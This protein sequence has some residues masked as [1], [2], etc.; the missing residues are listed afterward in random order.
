[1]TS[2]MDIKATKKLLKKQIEKL[3]EYH[4]WKYI[5]WKPNKTLKY[6][7]T[8]GYMGEYE[9]P[10]YAEYKRIMKKN[11]IIIGFVENINELCSRDILKIIDEMN[12]ELIKLDMEV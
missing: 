2:V 12:E 11:K 1:M 3:E 7:D 5:V 6:E 8:D 10:L 9:N 4:Y